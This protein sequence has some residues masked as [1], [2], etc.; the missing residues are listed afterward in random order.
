MAVPKRKI[1][2]SRRGMRRSHLALTPAR[3]TTC[4]ECGVPKHP[5]HI[6]PDCGYYRSQTVIDRV[7]DTVEKPEGES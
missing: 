5:H 3:M 4:P 1:S 6:C 7:E 2:S